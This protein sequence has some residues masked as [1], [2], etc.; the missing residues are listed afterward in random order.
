MIWVKID[1]NQLNKLI[2]I[3]FDFTFVKYLVCSKNRRNNSPK[4]YGGL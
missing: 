2:F 1:P 4:V 3:W